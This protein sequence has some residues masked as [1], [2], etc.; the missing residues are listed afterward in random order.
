[1]ADYILDE[2]RYK[3]QVYATAGTILVYDAAAEDVPEDEK[4]WHPGS[5]NKVLDLAHPSLFPLERMGGI[6]DGLE[7]SAVGNVI[8]LVDPVISLRE[9]NMALTLNPPTFKERLFNE[10]FHYINNLHPKRHK[11]LYRLIEQLVDYSIPLW[12]TALTCARSRNDLMRI[13]CDR[14]LYNPEFKN[15]SDSDGP[16]RQ[17]GEDQN[18]YKARKR[19]S[20]QPDP[21]AKF[22]P[23]KVND[24]PVRLRDQYKRHGLQV[25]VKLVNIVLTPGKPEYGA[26]VWHIE[27]QLNEHIVANAIYYYSSENVTPAKLEFRKQCNRKVQR[28]DTEDNQWLNAVFGLIENDPAVQKPGH[29]K[30]LALF[31]V[32]PNI[33]VISTANIPCQ[34]K[35]WWHAE[36]EPAVRRLPPEVQYEILEYIDYPI[37]MKRAKEGREELADRRKLFILDQEN[38]FKWFKI[39]LKG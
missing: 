38:Q 11:D 26:G 23:P 35:D 34:R 28:Y 3:A 31:L 7:M 33:K 30:I 10:R 21:V 15:L 9:A 16:Q 2:L 24:N 27:G 17:P 37:T 19:V 12:D 22:A 20:V 14:A 13:P 18:Q 1:M 29:R 6:E 5:D 4:D 8:P 25:I 36:F 39:S 32:D